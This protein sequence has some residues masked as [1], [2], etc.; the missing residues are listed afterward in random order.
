[1]VVE[2]NDLVGYKAGKAV[3]TK[4]SVNIVTDD[5]PRRSPDL[6]IND[7]YVWRAVNTRMRAQEA[8]FPTTFK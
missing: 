8:N 2:D 4:K 3:R 7:Y 6:N 1:M 5:L